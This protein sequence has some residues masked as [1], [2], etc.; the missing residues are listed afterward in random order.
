M[1]WV[2]VVWSMVAAA[3]LTLAGM[4]LL[5]WFMRRQ[6]WGSLLFTVTAATTAALA[7]CELWMMQAGTA[8]EFGRAVRWMHVPVAVLIISLVVFVRLHLHAGR[9]WLAWAAGSVRVL[10]LV[11]NFLYGQN[12]NYLEVASL[13]RVPFLGEA[14]SVG[15]GVSNPL[16]LV[17]QLSLLLFVSFVVDAAVA[18]W[19]RGDRRQ[20]LAIGGSIV[21]FVLVGSVQGVLAIWQIVHAPFIGSLFFVPVV[22]AMGYEMSRDVLR[23]VQLSDDLRESEERMTLAVEAAGFGI[24]MWSVPHNQIWGSAR[25][26]H[27][28]GFAPEAVVT[29][30]QVIARIHPDDREDVQRDAQRALADRLDYA[31]EHRLVLPDG[32]PRW[33]ATRGRMVPDVPGKPARMLGAA[34]DIT[35]R[36]LAEADALRQ[37]TELA[38][39][40]R[41]TM[42]GE[43]SGSI[44]HELNQPLTAILSNAQ[45]AKRFLAQEPVDL[46]ELRDILTD[47]VEQ[48]KRAGEVIHRLRLLL[49]KG[50]VQQRPMDVNEVVQE[51]LKLIRSDLLNQ[52][53]AASTELASALADVSGD[54]VQLQQVL[55]NLVIN[56]S[57]AMSG[58]AL[59]DR[60]L[61]VR[62]EPLDG[63]GVRVSVSDAGAGIAPDHLEQVFE[64]FFSTKTHGL[65]LGLSV[66]R[67]IVTAHG[68]T[69]W[70]THNPQRGTTFHFTLPVAG[71]ARS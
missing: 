49:K 58:N 28:F 35:E 8:A 26:R 68:G 25:W 53:V 3:C 24:W 50:E 55:V 40:S 15:D 39:L 4:H 42:L 29:F 10:S 62:T 67:S 69:L 30:E 34:I 41:V 54:R 2:T 13:R 14:V 33:I 43:L 11:L 16:M 46:D 9:S 6:A 21:F 64:P 57:D 22:A 61:V 63:G 45:A 66:C 23:A 17:G 31:R 44:A 19:R 71:G 52:S 12:L 27:L 59:H 38:H 51:G 70:A 37:R 36:K 20:A 48:D 7:F 1:S 65:G 60:Q 5:V 47:I 18:V 56:A 32:T